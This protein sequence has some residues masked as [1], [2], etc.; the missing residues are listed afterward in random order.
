VIAAPAARADD[1]TVRKLVLLIALLALVAVGSTAAAVNTTTA[2]Q[3]TSRFKAATGA[4]LVRNK[5]LSYAG[6]YAAYDLGAHPS[7]ANAARFGQ[8]TVYLVTAADPSADVDKLLA[9]THTGVKGTPGPGNIYWEAGSTLYGD[10]Y[11]QAKRQY[12]QNVVVK[13]TTTS[14]VRKTDATWK[15]LH[16]ALTA[17][18]K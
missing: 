4:K 5:T 17:A 8:F 18:T 14:A 9:D 10:K 2:A 6:H 13:W 16:T 11:W 12:S 3:L 15:R 7:A 1:Q